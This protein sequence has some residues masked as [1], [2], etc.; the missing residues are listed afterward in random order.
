MSPNSFASTV[1]VKSIQTNLCIRG[2]SC[3]CTQRCTAP[4]TPFAAS[5]QPPEPRVATMARPLLIYTNGYSWTSLISVRLSFICCPQPANRVLGP[6][7]I[8]DGP[9]SPPIDG[10][11][12]EPEVESEL[13]S[14][15]TDQLQH[16][17]EEQMESV[18]E[19]STAHAVGGAVPHIA[20]ADQSL[21]ARP[22][23]RRRCPNTGCTKS[24][25]HS[26]R[27]RLHLCSLTR[28]WA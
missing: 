1:G 4:G 12:L 18:H 19:S 15:N 9:A 13:Q 23:S 17:M 16:S 8:V 21:I 6:V 28:I 10:H 7:P 5:N 27:C 25:T 22:E 11:D 2:T 3:N 24:G 26:D 20:L 14:Q